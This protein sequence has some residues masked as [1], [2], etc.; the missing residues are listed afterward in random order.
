MLNKIIARLGQLGYTAVAAD[1]AHITSI[2][3][4]VEA[5]IEN[6]CNISEVP[7]ELEADIIEMVAYQFLM[8][9][10]LSGGLTGIN[11]KGISSITEGDTTVSYSEDKSSLASLYANVKESFERALIPFRKMRW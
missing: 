8:D 9:K 10:S 5:D 2:L 11:I 3:T 6:F 7:D 4:K 1:N